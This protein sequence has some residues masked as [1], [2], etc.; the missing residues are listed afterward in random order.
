[1]R[2]NVLKQILT[3][4]LIILAFNS[5]GYNF[6]VSGGVYTTENKGV[7]NQIIVFTSSNFITTSQT[8][9][10]TDE[11]GLFQVNF[12]FEK[13][14][15]NEITATYTDSCGVSSTQTLKV[16]EQGSSN[17]TFNFCNKID[18]EVCKADFYYKPD[19]N[20]THSF[21]FF[22]NSYSQDS[23]YS[24]IW[25]FGDNNISTEANPSHT[26]AKDGNY[27]VRLKMSGES[28]SAV[29]EQLVWVGNDT[30]ISIDACNP[31]FSYRQSA[32][33]PF[34]IYFQDESYSM[35]NDMTS[36]WDFGDGTTSNDLNPKHLYETAGIYTVTLNIKNSM[37]QGKS[38]TATVYVNTNNSDQCSTKFYYETD[39]A[40]YNFNF[41]SSVYSQDSTYSLFWDFGDNNISTETNPSHTFAKDGNYLVRLKMSGESCSA[42]SEQ[43]IYIGTR[44]WYPE[45]CQAFFYPEYVS[46]NSLQIKFVDMSYGNGKIL[47]YK[48]NFG[49]SLGS[50]LQNPTH[51]YAQNGEYL[52]AL[53]IETEN[54]SSTFYQYIYVKDRNYTNDCKTLFFPEFDGT[55]SVKFFDL[56]APQPTNWNWT[57]SDNSVATEQNPVHTFEGVGVYYVSLETSTLSGCY[58]AFKLEIELYEI[59]TKSEKTYAGKINAAYAIE[60]TNTGIEKPA[61]LEA[62]VKFYPNPVRDILNIELTEISENSLIQIYT[63]TGQL[64]HS[65]TIE[66][67]NVEI[68]TSNFANGI[69]IARIKIDN[70]TS[71]IKFVK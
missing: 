28:C 25:D 8:K 18:V 9:A 69:Y 51:T 50:N 2:L 7:A 39:D 63:S 70:E 58:S 55:L 42:V 52:V 47:S 24:L 20:S 16:S 38:Y 54:C 44:N 29:S 30:L 49:D 5:F 48:W 32:E 61:N 33:N 14:V 31:Y 67:R 37:C 59:N 56:S 15:V 60:S 46:D 17:M 11:N 68:N 35:S 45:A 36:A 6:I 1:M 71:N 12:S 21:L 23:T 26:F 65:Q 43:Y 4:A 3:S 22:N 10:I 41:Y 66:D 57:F 53:T 62:N 27:L 13:G 40:G 34:V 19:E 64:I